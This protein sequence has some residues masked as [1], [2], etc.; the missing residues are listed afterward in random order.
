MSLFLFL[1]LFLLP[2]GAQPE[3]T[4]HQ[5]ITYTA[6]DG[7][8]FVAPECVSGW[9]DGSIVVSDRMGYGLTRLDSK[10]TLLARAGSRGTAPGEFRSPGPLSCFGDRLAI[11]DFASTRVQ[12]FGWDLKHRTTLTSAGAVVDLHYDA[13]GGLW[14]SAQTAG[15]KRLLKYDTARTLRA[16]LTPR[17]ISG[18]P[19]H[20]VFLCTVS[21]SGEVFLSYIVQ[22]VVEV[23]DTSGAFLRQFTIPGLPARSPERVM[24]H[25]DTPRSIRVPAG[26]IVQSITV[27]PGGNLF[28]L[29]ADYAENPGRDIFVLTPAGDMLGVVTLPEAASH[30]W[31]SPG[32]HLLCI[33]TRN[34][35]GVRYE[36]DKGIY[37]NSVSL[38]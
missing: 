15:G 8:P 31:I 20:D 28:V 32:G 14:I 5:V 4:L 1:F 13:H 33:H 35:S 6:A 27:D 26:N 9:T 38:R 34:A 37:G 29:A 2:R 30:I 16:T 18:R 10:G 3:E 24:N 19:F 11:A 17:N 12:V 7:A 23:W 22:N 21:T 36:F 25:N